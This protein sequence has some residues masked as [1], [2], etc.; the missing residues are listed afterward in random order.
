M[1]SANVVN[2][3]L[4]NNIVKC[5]GRACV[6]SGGSIIANIAHRGQSSQHSEAPVMSAQSSLIIAL[7]VSISG[8]EITGNNVSA[9]GVQAAVAGA[10]VAVVNASTRITFSNISKNILQSLRSSSF[11]SGAG[12]YVHGSRASLLISNASVEFNDAGA[13]GIGGAIFVGDGTVA[14]C[15][16]ATIGFNKAQFG[17]GIYFD[18]SAITVSNSRVFKNAADQSGGGILS[19]ISS[20]NMSTVVAAIVL[21]NVSFYDNFITNDPS[22]YGAAA[23][24]SGNV[25][26]ELANGTSFAMIGSASFTTSEVV[27]SVDRRMNEPK[28]LAISCNAGGLLRMT[29][30][31]I[32]K[33]ELTSTSPSVAFQKNTQ[34]SPHCPNVPVLSFDIGLN[35]FFASCVPCPRTTY[36]LEVSSLSNSINCLACPVGAECDGG[37]SFHAKEKYWGWKTSQ[38]E[39]ANPFV[40]LPPG[41]GCRKNCNAIDNCGGNRNGVLCGDCAPNFSVAFFSTECVPSAQCAGWKWSLL[42]FMCIAFQFMFSLWI[43]WSSESAILETQSSHLLQARTAL[44]GISLFEN[45]SPGEILSLVAKMKLVTVPAQTT[46]LSQGH[47]GEHMYIIMRGIVKVYKHDGET[48]ETLVAQL[49]SPSYFGELSVITGANCLASVRTAEDCDLWRLD[50]SCFDEITLEDKEKFVEINR[51]KYENSSIKKAKMDAFNTTDDQVL[52]DAF[53]ILMWFYQLAGVM[54]SVSS[55]LSYVTGSEL[56]YSILSF[57]VN[58]EAQTDAAGSVQSQAQKTS[59]NSGIPTRADDFRFCVSADL[60]MFQLYSSNLLYYLMWALVMFIMSRPRVWSFLRNLVVRRFIM[61]AQFLDAIANRFRRLLG[62][63]EEDEEEK[64]TLQE[65]ISQRVAS[66][67][68][69]RG[70]VIL[71]WFVTCYS[72]LASMF[73]QGTACFHLKGLQSSSGSWRWLYDGEVACFSDAGNRRGSWQFAAAFGVVVVF[74]APAALWRLMIRF[75]KIDIKLRTPFQQS[76]LEA[77]SGA[78]SSNARHWKVLL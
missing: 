41:Y 72:A 58:S 77:Y 26:L 70:P 13:G 19:V 61:F 56:A 60:S 28:D 44:E 39:L 22:A 21:S 16:S 38:K 57:F 25:R 11:I 31:N 27:L 64:H 42:I 15:D 12:V 74:I 55:P 49:T 33:Q 65:L 34:C 52:G 69:I 76:F 7:H 43:F 2:S 66:T 1:F 54:L 23:F 47:V 3:L 73:M 78:H 32:E 30:T 67:V 53:G 6:A 9:D 17:G 10:G 36:S 46:I 51:A 37:A 20:L 75:H 8:C 45:L 29:R 40:M 18:G 71:K 48:K 68:E 59:E 50:R 62:K 5:L 35:G 4:N 63:I 14:S 24:I